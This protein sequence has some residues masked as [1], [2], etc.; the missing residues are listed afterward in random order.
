MG[1]QVVYGSF[2]VLCRR[3]K[4]TDEEGFKRKVKNER[5][6]ER[7]RIT[8]NEGTKKYEKTVN[9]FL[10]RLY[11]NMKSRISGIQREKFHLYKGKS[12]DICKDDFY[13]WAKGNSTFNSLFD[14]YV[15]SG[16]DQKLAPSVDR[17][18]SSLGYCFGNVE[19]VTHSVNSQRGVIQRYKNENITS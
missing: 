17:I 11:R 10:M 14:A 2:I 5:Q 1:V 4:M 15:L 8:G 9:G 18:D 16:Y 3:I 7:R 6:R 13:T 12:L 19:W